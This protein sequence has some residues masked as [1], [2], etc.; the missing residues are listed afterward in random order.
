MEKCLNCTEI[1]HYVVE[2]PGAATQHFCLA[3]LPRFMNPQKLQDHVRLY[4]P[5]A[6]KV[7]DLVLGTPEE[8]ELPATPVKSKKKAAAKAEPVVEEA[9]VVEETVVEPVVEEVPVEE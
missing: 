8:A 9:P 5:Q 1:A 4:S 7:T 3:H 2:N 6:P